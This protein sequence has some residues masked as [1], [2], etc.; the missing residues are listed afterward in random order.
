MIRI[1]HILTE[2][3]IHWVRSKSGLIYCFEEFIEPVDKCRTFIP[4]LLVWRLWRVP[5][6]PVGH[7]T[8]LRSWQRFWWSTRCPRRGP[9]PSASGPLTI[10]DQL[11]STSVAWRLGRQP[12]SPQGGRHRR[13]RELPTQL[14]RFSF[15]VKQGQQCFFSGFKE[16][17]I[18]E[19]CPFKGFVKRRFFHAR[20]KI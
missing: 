6:S 3:K 15:S 20:Q 9:G 19:S 10:H 17:K 2:S 13:S 5:R 1:D 14:Q 18:T 4:Y 8:R 7:W 16:P 11:P 12:C